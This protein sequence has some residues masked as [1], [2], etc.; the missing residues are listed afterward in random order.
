MNQ[1]DQAELEGGS[2]LLITQ[3]SASILAQGTPQSYG[4][5]MDFWATLFRCD[6]KFRGLLQEAIDLSLM[7]Q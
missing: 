4:E 6:P 7:E 1:L 2:A 3:S 5:I